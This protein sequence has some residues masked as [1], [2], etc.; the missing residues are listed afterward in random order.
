M[1][2]RNFQWPGD[3]DEDD[4]RLL[5]LADRVR[6]LGTDDAYTLAAT[7][8]ALFHNGLDY[9]GGSDLVELAVRLNPNL[10]LAYH[11]RGYLRV[12]SGLSDAA[13]VDFERNMRLNPRDPLT[14][15][16]L[17]GIAFGH[18]NA[19]RYAEAASW[20]DKSIRE[21]PYFAG[22]LMVAIPCYVEAGRM[23]D[24]KRTMST[25]LR[26]VPHAN[27]QMRFGAIRLEAL[28][29]KFR[30]AHLKAGLPE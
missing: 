30:E 2:R 25:L 27:S 8:A 3:K 1:W 4:A 6:D 20:A 10:A 17:F 19:G 14:F 22:G 11:S 24:A 26:L 29:M 9:D 21:F 5:R 18:H 23:D 7:G 28:R 13:I 12:W 15:L 16:S